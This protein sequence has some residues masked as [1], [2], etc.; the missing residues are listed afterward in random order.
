MAIPQHVEWLLEGASAW[1]DRRWTSDF[2]PELSGEDLVARLRGSQSTAPGRSPVLGEANLSKALLSDCNLS[3]TSFLRANF[4]GAY[5]QRTCFE[6]ALLAFAD[7]TQ[8]NL[9]GADL[10]G[11]NLTGAKLGQA[12][13]RNCKLD[14]ARLAD[15]N[16]VGADLTDSRFWRASVRGLISDNWDDCKPTTCLGGKVTSVHDVLQRIR[17]LKNRYT[18]ERPQEPPIFYFRGESNTEWDLTPS[19]MRRLKDKRNSLRGIEEKMLVDLRSRRPEDFAE[20]NSA[21]EQMVIARHHGLPTRLLDVTHN[22]LVALFN[23]T[24]EQQ[25]CPNADSRIHVFAVP[26]SLVKQFNSATPSA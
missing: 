6:N 14:R 24:E 21:L 20:T 9:Q 4:A 11:A 13:L 22:P 8:A 5:L 1:N 3:Y 17:M 19:V 15:A 18:S 2:I 7:L 23:A 16:L 25:D 12:N 26:T 10:T